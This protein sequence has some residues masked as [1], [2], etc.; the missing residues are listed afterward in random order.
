MKT[1]VQMNRNDYEVTLPDYYRSDQPKVFV[2]VRRSPV[3]PSG[4]YVQD[5][6]YRTIKPHSPKWLRAVRLAK[7]VLLAKEARQRA[8]N[9]ARRNG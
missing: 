3:S 7:E 2:I 8:D 1:I 9:A 4:N 5:T 6:V